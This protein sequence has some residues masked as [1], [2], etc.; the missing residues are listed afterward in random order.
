MERDSP[1]RSSSWKSLKYNPAICFIFFIY[2]TSEIYYEFSVALLSEKVNDMGCRLIELVCPILE[3]DC[4]NLL[5]LD[6]IAFTI[7]VIRLK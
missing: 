4:F 2:F 6:I 7:T 5:L 1:A 3:L